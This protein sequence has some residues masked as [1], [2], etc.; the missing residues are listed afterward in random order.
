MSKTTV[1]SA[2]LFTIL[3]VSM[4]LFLVSGCDRGPKPGTVPDE[5]KEAGRTPQSFPAADE[6]Y[7]HDMDGALTLHDYEVKGRN[8]WIVWTGGN[9][10]LWDKLTSLSFGAL[11]LLKTISNHPSL[12]YSRDNRWRY[13]GVVNE[14]GFEK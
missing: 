6:D 8:T 1:K 12:K 10:H 2:V 13:L 5:A 7:F 3:A 9:D 14:P 4:S 11:D